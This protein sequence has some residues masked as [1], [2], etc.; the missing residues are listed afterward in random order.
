MTGESHD[1]FGNDETVSA[2][3]TGE[4]VFT[5]QDKCLVTKIMMLMGVVNTKFGF[6]RFI[7]LRR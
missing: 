5:I 2:T 3:N 6:K 4:I 7:L 1:H